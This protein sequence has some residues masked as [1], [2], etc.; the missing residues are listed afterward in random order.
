MKRRKFDMRPKTTLIYA[1]DVFLAK[2]IR[3]GGGRA[4]RLI[5]KNFQQKRMGY[6][7]TSSHTCCL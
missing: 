2:N 4:V 1:I 3:I 6:P 7:I 5:F